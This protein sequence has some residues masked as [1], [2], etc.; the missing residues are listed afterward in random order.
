MR[1]IADMIR[2]GVPLREAALQAKKA[3]RA[4]SAFVEVVLEDAPAADDSADAAD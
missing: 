3:K 1:S 2:A 4:K